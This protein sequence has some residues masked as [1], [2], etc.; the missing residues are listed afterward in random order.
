MNTATGSAT[1]QMAGALGRRVW[2]APV[3]LV[4]LT[5]FTVRAFMD[6]RHRG[7]L[8]N[9]ASRRTLVTQLI[10]T[11]IDALPMLMLV[12]VVLGVSVSLQLLSLAQ[13]LALQ[14]EVTD[15]LVNFLGLQ[16]GTILT[17]VIVIA[18]SGLAMVIDIGN[19]KLKGEIASLERLGININHLLIAPRLIA[20]A[21]AQLVL[22][23]FFVV[24]AL[25]G[26]VAGAAL[27]AADSYWTYIDAMTGRF[28]PWTV[29]NFVFQN[30]L[31]GLAIAATACF[32][33]LHVHSS[34]TELPQQTQRA[35]ANA[36]LI[37]F[38]LAGLLGVFE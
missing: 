20:T 10:F 28:D 14:S 2:R 21:I 32:H 26:G 1:Q 13:T 11:G 23:T 17:A 30:L 7:S 35:I 24:I 16:L 22:A 27:I 29:G 25:F 37:V 38:L 34:T 5:V 31:F 4:D 9:P 15:L 18:R 19:M 12:A 8:T 36:L 33:A 6:C 3:Y